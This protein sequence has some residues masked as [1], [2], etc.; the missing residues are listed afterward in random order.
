MSKSDSGSM[1]TLRRIRDRQAAE[2]R[3][4]SPKQRIGYLRKKAAHVAPPKVKTRS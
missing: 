3:G 2:M 4:M 1:E